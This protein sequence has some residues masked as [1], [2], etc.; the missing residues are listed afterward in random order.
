VGNNSGIT[1]TSAT[2]SISSALTPRI[3]NIEYTVSIYAKIDPKIISIHAT[4]LIL[5]Q[6]K[7]AKKAAAA[8]R[9]S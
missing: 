5:G 2:T 9:K 4:S 8:P 3:F 7:I 1:G 6:R